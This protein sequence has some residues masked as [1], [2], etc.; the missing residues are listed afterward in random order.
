MPPNAVLRLVEEWRAGRG[1]DLRTCADELERA[2]R[3]DGQ[4]A[5]RD[6]DIAPLGELAFFWIEA[7][8]AGDDGIYCDTS[9]NPIIATFPPFW[10][11]CKF[12]EWSALSKA[13]KWQPFN[14]PLPP[15]PETKT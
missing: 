12:G 14:E 15:P 13:T 1:A 6:I 5:W 9:G 11:L 10:K 8:K 3:E 7:K 4:S 2:I